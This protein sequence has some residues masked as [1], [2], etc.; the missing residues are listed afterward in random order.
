VIHGQHGVSERKGTEHITVR[1][2]RG[3]FGK[4]GMY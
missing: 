4:G 1:E 3:H 2:E